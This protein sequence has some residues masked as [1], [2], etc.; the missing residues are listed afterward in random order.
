MFQRPNA[1]V[2]AYFGGNWVKPSPPNASRIYQGDPAIVVKVPKETDPDRFSASHKMS[3]V[4]RLMLTANEVA[5]RWCHERGIPIP[6]RVTQTSPDD[7]PVGFFK[8]EIQPVIERGE[9]VG[10]HIVRQYF[11]MVG[12][13][14]LST[15]PG[16]HQA[17][18]V[19]M[20][21]KATSPLRRYPDLLLHWQ[22]GA[23]L[24]HEAKTGQSLIGNKNDDFLPFSQEDIEA[25]L[26]RIEMRER[27]IKAAHNQSTRAWLCQFLIR[28]WEHGE[29]TL[30]SPLRVRVMRDHGIQ[31]NPQVERGMLTN[32]ACLV[33]MKIPPGMSKEDIEHGDEFEVELASVNA[34]TNK[35]EVAATKRWL[36][37]E[38]STEAAM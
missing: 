30:P 13:A 29:A 8:R 24:L 34:Y 28:A 37:E 23:A 10:E 25:K 35:I 2:S 15:T 31:F 12:V 1:T 6:Y 20:I 32:F 19:D 18:G 27:A 22:I 11:D 33:D 14:Q 21:A 16:P 36:A 5:A 26:P 9:Q 3:A 38:A 7:D 4:A 17:L